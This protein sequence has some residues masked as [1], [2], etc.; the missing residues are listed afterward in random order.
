MLGPRLPAFQ[1]ARASFADRLSLQFADCILS[2]AN[3]NIEYLLG[4]LDGIAR[5][6]RHE[7]SIAQAAPPI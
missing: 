3:G 2:F 5:T 4:K 6:L 1:S 7:P